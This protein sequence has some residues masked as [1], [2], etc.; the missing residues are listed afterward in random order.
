MLRLICVY[1]STF[2]LVEFF[3]L[4]S[5]FRYVTFCAGCRLSRHDNISVIYRCVMSDK[6]CFLYSTLLL[7]R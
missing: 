7:D 3:V 6:V 5:F 4:G 2:C 1:V